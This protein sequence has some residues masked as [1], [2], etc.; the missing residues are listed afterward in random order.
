[1]PRTETA[2]AIGEERN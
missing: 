1:M 2:N